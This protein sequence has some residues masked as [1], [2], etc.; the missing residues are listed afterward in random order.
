[1]QP[2]CQGTTMVSRVT[3]K[4]RILSAFF[5][6]V[7]VTLLIFFGIVQTV[8]NLF[9]SS[10]QRWDILQRRN[11]GSLH[12]LSGT[13]WTDRVASV[14]PFAAHL[15]GIKSA[16]ED[17]LNLN[18]TPK[19]RHEVN[20]AITYVSSFKRIV[21]S[22]IWLM[23][24][25]A[26]DCRNQ[27][28]QSRN[29]TIDIE[30]AN[31]ESLL[32]EMKELR[33]KWNTILQE[34]KNVARAMGISSELPARRKRKRR[35][36]ADELPSEVL[37]SETGESEELETEFKQNDLFLHCYRLSPRWFDHTLHSHKKHQFQVRFPLELPNNER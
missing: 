36:L 17:L 9:A 30:V 14:R 5:L 11:G 6:H 7:D 2:T 4:R 24:L 3:S 23:I 27:V 13:R 12:G 31:L 26:I 20:G 19:T 1:M 15:P 37:E 10:P 34:S 8:Y 22:A 18:L 28:I 33:E 35:C 32:V 21:M 29:A 25:V 16:L